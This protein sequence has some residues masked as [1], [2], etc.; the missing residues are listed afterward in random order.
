[1]VCRVCRGPAGNGF[2]RCYQ[3]ELAASQGGGL[4]ADVVAPVG[5]AVRGSGLA[6]DL[7]AYKSDRVDPTAAAA[8]AG[9]LRELLAAFLGEHGEAVWAAA[10]MLAGPDAVAVVPSGQGRP[11]AHPLNRIVRSSVR[12]PLIK[13]S[14]ALREI[15]D[16]GLN[17]YWIQVGDSVMDADVLVVDDTWVSGGSAQ[18]VAV[19][20]KLAGAR[21][22]AV[23][24]LGRHV[25]PANPKSAALV[26]A[27]SAGEGCSRAWPGADAERRSAEAEEVGGGGGADGG[28]EGR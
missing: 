7:R 18:S 28:G 6:A 15:H 17:R 11:G 27:V 22:V 5:Y 19:A 20:L 25:N 24:V 23:V 2:A 8:A 10:G 12:L 13:L 1:M 14:L 9:R 16:R 3:C 21:R 26:Q 4:L